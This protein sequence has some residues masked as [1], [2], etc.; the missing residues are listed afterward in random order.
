LAT[1]AWVSLVLNDSLLAKHRPRTCSHGTRR[2]TRHLRLRALNLLLDRHGLVLLDLVSE[3][4]GIALLKRWVQDCR[5]QIHWPWPSSSWPDNRLSG[6]TTGWRLHRRLMLLL[7]RLDWNW[8]HRFGTCCTHLVYRLNLLLLWLHRRGSDLLS[9][10]EAWGDSTWTLTRSRISY[11]PNIWVCIRLR[12]N[13]FARR[14]VS[15]C[16]CHYWIGHLVS[17]SSGAHFR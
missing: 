2:W 9:V 10:R 8:L 7:C 15:D 4:M 6:L 5:S 3:V 17:V 13:R 16:I 1:L 14:R 11:W 12:L